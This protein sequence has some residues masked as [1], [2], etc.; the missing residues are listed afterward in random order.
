MLESQVFTKN[1]LYALWNIP[2]LQLYIANRGFMSQDSHFHLVFQS[3]FVFGIFIKKT[4]VLM[5]II[6]ILS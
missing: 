4:N 2:K 1:C 5:I 3:D 6:I